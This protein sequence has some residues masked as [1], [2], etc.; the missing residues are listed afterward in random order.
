[1]VVINITKES[2]YFISRL[3]NI[4]HFQNQKLHQFS[5]FSVFASIYLADLICDRFLLLLYSA[6]CIFIR[7]SSLFCLFVIYFGTF[8]GLAPVFR[9]QHTSAGKKIIFLYLLHVDFVINS[10]WCVI[11]ILFTKNLIFNF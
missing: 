10:I 4:T 9:Y 6:F 1:M 2:C 7:I 8:G 5:G 11:S 3:K